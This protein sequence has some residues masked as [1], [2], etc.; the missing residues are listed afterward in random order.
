MADRFAEE[1]QETMTV[2]EAA[3]LRLSFGKHKG[4]ALGE[5][6]KDKAADG[7]SYL[8]WLSK[9]ER[10]DAVIKKA[11]RILFDAVDRENGRAPAVDETAPIPDDVPFTDSSMEGMDV[12]A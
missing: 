4:R 12:C 6:Y 1:S 10:T 11:I 9:Q 8:E 5:L 3:A 2:S 7:K